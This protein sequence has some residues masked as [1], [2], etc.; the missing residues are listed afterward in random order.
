[1]QRS[2][3]TFAAVALVAVAMTSAARA[4]S[5][6][7]SSWEAFAAGQTTA[8]T[9]AWAGEN[10][11]FAGFAAPIVAV[12]DTDS[13]IELMTGLA[14][15]EPPAI[16]LAGMALGGVVCGRSILRKRRVKVSGEERA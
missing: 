12:I 1:M 15:P 11:T 2:T 9:F 13:N 7:P 10:E 14:A 8:A 3:L 4:E 5:L 16:V 6:L